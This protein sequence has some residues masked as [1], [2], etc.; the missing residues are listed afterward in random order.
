MN[1]TI[2]NLLLFLALMPSLAWSLPAATDSLNLVVERIEILGA[3]KTQHSVILNYLSFA[4]GHTVDADILARDLQRLKDTHFFKKV[5]IFTRPG[6]ERGDVIVEITVQERRF[7]AFYFE[8]GHGELDGWYIS[9]LGIRFDNLSGHGNRTGIQLYASEHSA[10]VH[11]FYAND[12][13]L[14]PDLQYHV[15]LLACVRNGFHYIDDKAYYQGVNQVGTRLVITPAKLLPHV[16]F[17][18]GIQR[19]RP[20]KYMTDLSVYD[21]GDD[22]EQRRLDL[23][24]RIL[25]ESHAATP[26]RLSLIAGK[27]SRDNDFFPTSGFWGQAVY[28]FITDVDR[29]SYHYHQVT[30]DGRYY[31]S[32]GS[33]VGA[34]R[35]KLASTQPAAPFYDRFYLGGSYS[36]R[37]Y[38]DYSLTPLGWG[39]QLGLLNMEYRLPL[40]KKGYPRHR[41]TAAFFVDSGA[42]RQAGEKD[43][44][45][46]YHAVGL[47]LRLR[48][49]FVGLLRADL[50]F[51]LQE[52]DP[53]LTFSFGNMF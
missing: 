47:G 7:P 21:D 50:G 9:P 3:E 46:F 26:L 2:K 37:G 32:I 15:S 10:G 24:P 11:G 20:D 51:P 49:P 27:D 6:S 45:H 41:W 48:L 34:L 31:R 17:A 4:A 14:H 30:L 19:V 43:A 29:G 13:R 40:S 36:V 38:E 25:R 1:T 12:K 44:V 18:M 8:G 33:G 23:P 39:T 5:A 16:S 28:D 52:Q 35:L 22:D 53:S 42:I